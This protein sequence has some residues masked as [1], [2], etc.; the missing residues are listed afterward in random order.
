MDAA[1]QRA[2]AERFD[3]VYL[4][5]ERAHIPLVLAIAFL[6]ASFA[7]RN[8]DFWR[9]LATGKKIASG[10]YKFFGAGNE[11]FTYGMEKVRWVNH[12]W[13]YDVLLYGLW[14][15]GAGPAVVIF[16]ALMVALLAGIM[17][18]TCRPPPDERIAPGTKANPTGWLAAIFVTL[19]LIAIASRMLLQPTVMS[20]VLLGLTVWALN[21]HCPKAPKWQLPLIVAVLFALWANVDAWLVLGPLAVALHL[22]GAIVDRLLRGASAP[23]GWRRVQSLGIALAAGLA[24]CVLNPDFHR[25][26]ELPVELYAPNLPA[27]LKTEVQFRPMF[28]APLDKTYYDSIQFGRTPAGLAYA[29]LI[30]GLVASTSLN[31]SRIRW[32]QLLLAAGFALLTLRNWRVIP[33]FAIVAAPIIV[34]NLHDWFARRSERKFEEPQTEPS[35]AP[36]SAMPPEQPG[37]IMLTPARMFAFFGIIGRLTTLG[38]FLVAAVLA[39]LGKLH[40]NPTNPIPPRPAA[41]VAEPDP[42]LERAAKLLQKWR[43]EGKLPKDARGFQSHPDV[44]NYCAWFAPDEKTFF[45]YRFSLLSKRAADFMAI[46]KELQKTLGAPVSEELAELFRKHDMSYVVV[47]WLTDAELNDGRLLTGNLFLN[48]KEWSLWHLEGR[49][50]MA[51]WNDAAQSTS[52]KF[53]VVQEAFGPQPER[54]PPPGK[55]RL[56]PMDDGSLQWQSPWES[57]ITPVPPDSP[58]AVSSSVYLMLHRTLQT[59][60]RDRIRLEYVYAIGGSVA[61]LV[62]ERSLWPIFSRFFSYSFD[63]RLLRYQAWQRDD[64]VA[65]LPILALRSA[66]R[67]MSNY[68]DDPLPYVALFHA[69]EYFNTGGHM[70]ETRSI[71]T[72]RQGLARV[73]ANEDRKRGYDHIITESYLKLVNFYLQPPSGD[74]QSLDLAAECLREALKRF[75][76]AP[77]AEIPPDAVPNV[78]KQL[79]DQLK[80][81]EGELRPRLDNFTLGSK[82]RDVMTQFKMARQQGLT[83]E[84]LRVLDENRSKGVLGADGAL[85]LIRMHLLLGQP[86]LAQNYLDQINI[87]EYAVQFHL[88]FKALQVET[89]IAAGRLDQAGADLEKMIAVVRSQISTLPLTLTQVILGHAG[90]SFIE[91]NMSPLAREFLGWLWL[92]SPSLQPGTVNSWLTY[93]SLC[94][95]RGMIAIEEG[96]NSAAHEYLQK[97]VDVPLYFDGRPVAERYLKLLKQE[98]K[99]K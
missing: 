2:M 31:V 85:H 89:H 30:V 11:S 69:T 81:L 28:I 4:W 22:L 79:A 18:L 32:P 52:L 42:S 49:V 66:R 8:S 51:G 94:S 43:A 62:C 15:A 64:Q 55:G 40:V 7:V 16:K 71:G 10:E 39:Y 53:D 57:Y 48:N 50:S 1:S 82:G 80:S 24:A 17:L 21:C 3:L 45:D 91:P 65:A 87:D 54:V 23:D 14:S 9:H 97:A 58:E 33:F 72:L 76:V 6:L 27:S 74:S 34:R 86:D 83:R 20:Y 73:A 75:A 47:S 88:P 77:P 60:V 38:L 35:T 41:W 36:I 26:F 78:E 90:A 84:A 44:A 96:N 13:A 61:G 29:L 92:S 5:I 67:G 99:A 46:R 12:S 56:I 63:E 37:G 25:I 68:P 19:A 93:T 59:M 95:Q 98:A 70:Q